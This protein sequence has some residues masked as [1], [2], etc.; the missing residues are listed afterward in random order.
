MDLEVT[1]GS[2]IYLGEGTTAPDGKVI[3]DLINQA[4]A[5]FAIPDRWLTLAGQP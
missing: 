1:L 3:L 5:V 2:D 4:V